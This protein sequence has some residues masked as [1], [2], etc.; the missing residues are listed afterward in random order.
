MT[1][2]SEECAWL[3]GIIEGEGSMVL[4]IKKSAK[5]RR[6][7][8]FDVVICNTDA[9]L[10][11]AAIAILEKLNIAYHI[12]ERA[13]PPLYRDEQ[14]GINLRQ[15]RK[16]ALYLHVR[17]LQSMAILLR[18]L[19]PHFRGEKVAKARIMLKFVENRMARN[20]EHRNSPYT[21]EDW[22]CCLE[23]YKASG[24]RYRASEA[25][26]K[27]VTRILRDYTPDDPHLKK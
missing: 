15:D 17:R 10:I 18:Q 16:N 8:R 20:N 21:K 11:E 1:T 27:E 3:A 23:F 12:N 6:S 2:T 5:D 9:L 24:G 14:G 22:M 13:Q 25:N 4:D 26:I 7:A 19:I